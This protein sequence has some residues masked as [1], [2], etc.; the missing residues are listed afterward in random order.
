MCSMQAI[1]VRARGLGKVGKRA[2]R[3]TWTS[4]TFEYMYSISKNLTQ[5]VDWW[6][7]TVLYSN[8]RRSELTSSASFYFRSQ[9]LQSLKV[10]RIWN[11]SKNLL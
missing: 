9:S 11:C 7:S 4:Q 5:N 8:V 10:I 2:Y 6:R 1:F 3:C